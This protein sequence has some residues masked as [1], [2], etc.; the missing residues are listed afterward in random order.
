MLGLTASSKLW[1][2]QRPAIWLWNALG[3]I[4]GTNPQF[5]AS[6]LVPVV[7]AWQSGFGVAK[8]VSEQVNGSIGGPITTT[9]GSTDGLTQTRIKIAHFNA[10]S[11]SVNIQIRLRAGT[12]ALV[13]EVLIPTAAGSISTH[14][15]LGS[16][17]QWFVIPPTCV[18]EITQNAYVTTAGR[19]EVLRCEMPAGGVMDS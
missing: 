15:V 4:V 18:M 17:R 7:D 5:I 8:Y 2:V 14:N 3:V 6:D 19:I 9:Y 10:G 11:T 16:G 12:G 1:R 13:N